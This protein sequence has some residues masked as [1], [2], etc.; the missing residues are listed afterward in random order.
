MAWL[1][2][3]FKCSRTLIHAGYDET[4]NLTGQV[5]GA[6]GVKTHFTKPKT[7]CQDCQRKMIFGQEPE[8]KTGYNP[9]R[10]KRT[11]EVT[12]RKD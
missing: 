8:T 12:Y 3:C 2:R 6:N 9:F 5:N 11:P 10:D 7:I 4:V 1:R